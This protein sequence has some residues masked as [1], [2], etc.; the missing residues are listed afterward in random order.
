MMVRV[1]GVKIEPEGIITF[2]SL[3]MTK[4]MTYIVGYYRKEEGMRD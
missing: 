1:Q 4:C 3:E 2:G